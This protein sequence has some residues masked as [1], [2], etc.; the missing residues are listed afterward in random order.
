MYGVSGSA[1]A[2]G[3]ATLAATGTNTVWMVVTGMAAIMLGT[4][5]TRLIP[6]KEF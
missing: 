4:M 3:A 5:L 1:G 6:K 2:A